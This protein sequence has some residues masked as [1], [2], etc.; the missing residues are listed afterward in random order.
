L[1]KS[2]V[3]FPC[4]FPVIER[5][6]LLCY[7]LGM[8]ITWLG[9]SCFRLKGSHGVVITDPYAADTGYIMGKQNARIVT[10]S[11]SHTDHS[12]RAA[13][14]GEPYVIDRPGEYEISD[15]LV[16]GLRTFHDNE[17]G[18]QRGKNII[19]CFEIDDLSICHLGDLGHALSAQQMELLKPVD[20]LLIPVGGVYTLD[21]PA[22]AAVVRQLEPKVVIPMHYQTKDL[23]DMQLDP[24]D[25]FL[26]EIGAAN[27]VPQPKVSVTK[28]SISETMQV[29][30]LDYPHPE[31]AA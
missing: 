9:H 26:Q 24:V 30:L 3:E 1:R 15:I 27:L 2:T 11:H 17:N 6:S 31:A 10:I 18:A 4:R 16:L 8:E 20:V 14:G 22:A 7:I 29:V 5:Q 19:F 12:N 13:V 21:A 23:K 25:R 28:S